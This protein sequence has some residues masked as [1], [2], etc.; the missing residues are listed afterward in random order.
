[1]YMLRTEH[2]RITTFDA[3]SRRGYSMSKS[4][5]VCF[6]NWSD[7]HPALTLI[8]KRTHIECT[9]THK[10]H[11]HTHHRIS[12]DSWKSRARACE[13]V[14]VPFV[15]RI[16]K[17]S[18]ALRY[19]SRMRMRDR[20]IPRTSVPVCPRDPS[21]H[22][23]DLTGT[24][25]LF[26]CI[27]QTALHQLNRVEYVCEHC[28]RSICY[29]LQANSTFWCTSYFRSVFQQIISIA[30]PHKRGYVCARAISLTQ[31]INKWNPHNAL[32]NCTP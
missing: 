6:V 23:S 2:L 19:H 27:R 11:T 12:L 25:L 24:N 9:H 32:E 22:I 13:R 28:T 14:C 29:N 21:E 7:A 20:L 1:M 3:H 26:E 16:P 18:L 10:K 17:R 15:T 30:Q 4:A 5:S 8:S 31:P